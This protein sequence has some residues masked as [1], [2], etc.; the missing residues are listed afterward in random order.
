M[1][2][3]SDAARWLG[4]VVIALAATLASDAAAQP[5]PTPAPDR[6]SPHHSTAMCSVCHDAE[7][8]LVASKPETCTLCHEPTM[9]SGAA[10]HL[11]IEA[12]RIARALP[13]PAPGATPA[14]PLDENGRI[15]CGTCHLFHDPSL[16]EAWL[17]D[18]WIPPATGLPGAV[19]RGVAARW[20]EIA[21]AHGQ[22]TVEAFFATSGT[23]ALRLPVD[24][25][26]LCT[27]CHGNP[28]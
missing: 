19:R 17:P 10:E 23:R 13:S 8:N 26:K 4:R 15:W 24:D 5:S 25:G 2:R 27:A 9:H 28:P 14:L 12:G 21:K 16:G 6:Q 3:M 1:A 18:S 20:E 22:S 7:L 11:R